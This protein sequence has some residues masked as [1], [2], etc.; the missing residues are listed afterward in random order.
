M[1]VRVLNYRRFSNKAEENDEY[2]RLLKNL[3]VEF[4]LL[5]DK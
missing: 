5:L 3:W 4:Y 2:F 1:E